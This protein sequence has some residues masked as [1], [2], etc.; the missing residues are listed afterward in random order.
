MNDDQI[1]TLAREYAEEKTAHISFKAYADPEF[2]KELHIRGCANNA[3]DV[4]EWL[5]RRFCLVEK[6]KLEEE[7]HEAT[8]DC[9][10]IDP[11]SDLWEVCHAKKCLLESLFPEI[12]KEV[13]G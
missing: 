1:T 5:L 10:N 7:F 6:S 3:K 11:C 2:K 9:G 4:I 13:E 12:R 8:M